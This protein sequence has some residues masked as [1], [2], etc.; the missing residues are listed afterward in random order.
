[1]KI[2][3][4][5]IASLNTDVAVKDIRQGVYQTAVYTS[6]CGLASTPHDGS[7]HQQGHSS[8]KEAGNL[9]NLSVTD[10]VD[11][12]KSNSQMEAAIGLATINS[13]LDIDE[14]RCREV[15]AADIIAEKGA[16]K[17]IAIIGHFPFVPSLKPVAANLWVI[18][19]NPHDGDYP[20]NAAEE[21]LPKADVVGI[22]GTALLNQTFDELAGYCRKDAFVVMLGGTTPLSP[23]LFDYGIDAI[24]G[25]MIVDADAALLSVS[26]GANFRQIKGKRLLT[27]M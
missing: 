5:V 22:T 12:A 21:L 26:Q 24:S 23:V 2:I 6:R 17:N 8:V 13:L 3:D 19:R 11:L 25:T 15:N 18:E 4:D 1:M 27:M 20:A 16:G 9:L 7:V 14:S 10:L